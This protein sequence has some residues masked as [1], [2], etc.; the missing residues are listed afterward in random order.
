MFGNK[1]LG[2]GLMRLPLTNP[3]V[4][5]SIDIDLLCQMVDKYL[6]NG[7]T[8][9]DTAWMYMDHTSEN[10][11]KTCI[12]DRYPRDSFTI[13]SKMPAYMINS[14]E[15]RD[16]LFNKQLEKTGAGYFDFYLLHDVNSGSIKNFDKYDVWGYVKKLKED[17]KI[18]HYG[19]S[20]HDG[21]EL[22]DDLLN[23]H[24]DVEFVQLQINYL[25]WESLGVRSREC[26]EVARAHGKD[27]IVMEPVKGGTLAKLPEQA[28]ELFK[29]H[30]ANYSI[31]SWAVRF[32]ASMPGVKLV[33]SG[34]TYMDQLENNM[35][36]MSDFTP[37]NKEEIDM[38]LKAADIINKSITI[39]CTG[40]SY[41]TVNCPMKIDIPRFISLYNADIQE[42]EGKGWTPQMG[43]YES[44]AFKQTTPA[45][46]IKCGACE[47][48]C[49]QHLHIRDYLVDIDNHFK[50]E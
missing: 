38:C 13:T 40:C 3:D 36:Y 37:L 30:D 47:S 19:F 43:L 49:P 10:A 46:C 9:F 33:L 45:D 48:M 18:K 12:V 6:E 27:I 1:I 39:P 15:D 8:Y 25:D 44:M 4:P 23:K 50:E 28:E 14:F 35:S 20:F 21:P 11:V 17:G 24:P 31:P 16:I 34:M 32:S 5:S 22:L 29:S 2:F 7:F 26:Y 41:C 42:V